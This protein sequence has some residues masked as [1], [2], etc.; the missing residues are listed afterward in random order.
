MRPGINHSKIE[1]A[2]KER[3]LISSASSCG[4]DVECHRHGD[5]RTGSRRKKVAVDL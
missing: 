3:S 4:A 2:E 1:T 5:Q